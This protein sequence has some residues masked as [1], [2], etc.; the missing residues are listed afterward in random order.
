MAL[1]RPTHRGLLGRQFRRAVAPWRRLRR[2]KELEQGAAR[3]ARA[4]SALKGFSRA[5]EK[6]FLGLGGGLQAQT[7]LNARLARE[8]DALLAIISAQSAEDSATSVAAQ[9][10]L[11]ILGCVDEA[12]GALDALV[13]RLQNFAARVERL[14]GEGG[15][16]RRAL[17]PLNTIEVLF[18]MEVARMGAEKQSVF[19]ALT[20][21]I[22]RLQLEV[23]GI[24]TQQEQTL[25][26]TRTNVRHAAEQLVARSLALG[27]ESAAKRLRVE[28]TLSGLR[29]EIE[30]QQKS[31]REIVGASREIDAQTG[32]VVMALQFQDIAR[33]KMEHVASGGGQV[34]EQLNGS[35][36]FLNGGRLSGI[37]AQCAVEAAQL[38]RLR[39]ETG[40]MV[41]K[42]GSGLAAVHRGLEQIEVGLSS[43][44]SEAAGPAREEAAG[45]LSGVISEV[46]PLLDVAEQSVHVAGDAIRQIDGAATAVARTLHKLALDIRLLAL[47]AQVQAAQVSALNGLEVLSAQ[48]C[49]IA[50]ET[51]AFS[52]A[53]SARLTEMAGEL[54]GVVNECAALRQQT[55]QMREN[56]R[57]RGDAARAR[58][59][60][61][62]KAIRE[63]SSLI[64]SALQDSGQLAEASAEIDEIQAAAC[65]AIDDCA[66]AFAALQTTLLAANAEVGAD[67]RLLDVAQRYTMDSERA[68]HRRALQN[69]AAIQGDPDFA[70]KASPLSASPIPEASAAPIEAGAARDNDAAPMPA[71][72]ELGANV[73]LF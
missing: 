55:S 24:F 21:E 61:Y 26:A 40:E 46:M 68:T 41:A 15:E 16:V 13:Q 30:G 34:V 56:A 63:H 1:L 53:S 38:E 48:T 43:R 36:N 44:V 71:T 70:P 19:G 67:E 12:R 72:E 66:A 11:D 23:E 39:S 52:L 18:R 58:L 22:R 8:S 49:S 29:R 14:E 5:Q 73:E 2:A 27:E 25:G 4:I 65:R 35:K 69:V 3:L 62:A 54:E 37:L 51:H 28:S 20:G 64:Q 47:N 57:A 6:T 17:A 59:S 42:L 33:Q 50:D 31:N 32:A 9:L 45:V 7:E 60:D 10:A